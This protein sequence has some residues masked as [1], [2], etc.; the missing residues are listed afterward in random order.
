MQN[1]EKPAELVPDV[2]I[3]ADGLVEQGLAG[4]HRSHRCAGRPHRL[5]PRFS[6]EELAEVVAAA[7]SV[8]STANGFC[9]DSAVA[10]ARGTPMVLA[11]ARYREDLARLQRQLF[12]AR[13]AVVRLGTNVNQA[14]AAL[15]VRGEAPAWLG[16]AIRLAARSVGRLDEVI[17]A[18]DRRLR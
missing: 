2:D 3:A 11:D 7:A 10:A 9:A 13:T 18:V 6:A 8:G 17:V 16:A 12:A 1:D 15:H 5:S 4:R 14:V